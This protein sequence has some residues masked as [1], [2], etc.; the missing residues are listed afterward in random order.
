M[1]AYDVEIENGDA[2]EASVPADKNGNKWM[3]EDVKIPERVEEPM[4]LHTGKM[5]KTGEQL[6]CGS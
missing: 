5:L 4:L 1:V 2:Y 3:L 6:S